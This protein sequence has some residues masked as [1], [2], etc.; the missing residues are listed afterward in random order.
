MAVNKENAIII[1]T[2]SLP[3]ILS[4]DEYSPTFQKKGGGG[5]KKELLIKIM[6]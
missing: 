5:K 6:M 1:I 4:T 3:F 2:S